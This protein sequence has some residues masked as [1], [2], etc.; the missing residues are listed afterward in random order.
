MMLFALAGA[1]VLLMIICAWPSAP[2]RKRFEPAPQPPKPE[3][4][5]DR[6]Y[7][8]AH[9]IPLNIWATLPPEKKRE[10]RLSAAHALNR[11]NKHGLGH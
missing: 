1:V 5:D 9:G 2:R 3:C 6:G 8:A 10:L 4:W 11:K 7:A